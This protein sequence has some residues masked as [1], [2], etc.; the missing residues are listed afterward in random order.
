MSIITCSHKQNSA[1]AVLQELAASW[2]SLYFALIGEVVREEE[3][4]FEMA[5][6]HL[7]HYVLR[8]MQYLPR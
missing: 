2:E 4:V 1:L 6:M 7:Y 5:N 3:H 8:Y